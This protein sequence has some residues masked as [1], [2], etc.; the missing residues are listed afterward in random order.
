MNKARKIIRE[1]LLKEANEIKDL[2]RNLAFILGE[3]IESSDDIAIPIENTGLLDSDGEDDGED[4]LDEK[5]L[6]IL[7]AINDSLVELVSE[8]NINKALTKAL[9]GKI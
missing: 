5:M 2:S 1:E 7:N 6:S 4:E 9:K 3:Y 8:K